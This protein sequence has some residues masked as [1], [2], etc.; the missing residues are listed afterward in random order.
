MQITIGNCCAFIHPSLLNMYLLPRALIISSL[1][2]EIYA[3]ASAA[4]TCIVT[5]PIQ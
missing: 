4:T 5:A 1:D 3:E 2:G